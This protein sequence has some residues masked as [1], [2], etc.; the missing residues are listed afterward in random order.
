MRWLVATCFSC[1]CLWQSVT[2]LAVFL[3]YKEQWSVKESAYFSFSI[4]CARPLFFFSTA[5]LICLNSSGLGYVLGLFRFMRWFMRNLLSKTFV[6]H[7]NYYYNE[8]FICLFIWKWAWPADLHLICASD[9]ELH[10]LSGCVMT[11]YKEFSYIGE[12][13]GVHLF[14]QCSLSAHAHFPSPPIDQQPHLKLREAE[15]VFL[16]GGCRGWTVIADSSGT[17]NGSSASCYCLCLCVMVFLCVAYSVLMVLS[18]SVIV[19]TSQHR[20]SVTHRFCYFV[21]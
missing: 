16:S 6:N 1:E 17:P 9:D 2:L 11:K 10:R 3:F 12:L 15:S 21:A 8:L 5:I 7:M 13:S 20:P 18:W 4:S 14:V 19:S